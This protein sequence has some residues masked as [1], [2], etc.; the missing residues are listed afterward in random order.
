M[1]ANPKLKIVS[2]GQLI[3]LQFPQ[4]FALKVYYTTGTS[5]HFKTVVKSG[6]S[7]V[8]EMSIRHLDQVNW[9]NILAAVQ[10]QYGNIVKFVLI[11]S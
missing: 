4:L 11:L 3:Q 7:N 6:V 10:M 5:E 9:E 8:F 2:Q 1:I